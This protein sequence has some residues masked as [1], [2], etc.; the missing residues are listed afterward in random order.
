MTAKILMLPRYGG[1]GASSRVR[2]LQYVPFL[3]GAG[4][5]VDVAPLL[6]DEY[7]RRTYQGRR[8]FGVI[9]QSY[10]G[11][12]L[13]MGRMASYDLLWVE[14]E[15]WPWL[16]AFLERAGTRMAGRVVVD[17]DDA[18]FH[19]Y[20]HH[21]SAIVRRM[22]GSKI[23]E[24]MRYA[25]AVTV[26]NAYLG[27]RARCAGSEKQLWLPTVVDL[28]RY[29]TPPNAEK[30]DPLVIGWIGSPATAA[31]LQLVAPALE[32]LS[33]QYQ[34]RCLAIGARADQLQGT[35]FE[36][37]SW[38]EGDEVAQLQ[39]FDIGIMPLPDE[40]W[41]RGKCGYKLIQYM[42]C[43]LPVVA[44]PVGIN[45]EIVRHG[46]NG[47][48]A[49]KEPEWIEAL[50]TLVADA[51]LRASMGMM[52]R[53]LVEDVYSLQAQAPRLQTLFRELVESHV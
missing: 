50:Q 53:Q 35:P 39:R 38:S 36:S 27:D 15:L 1:L 12:M 37:V 14:K 10:F 43:G 31:Y 8:A 11:R 42:A 23:D 2:F 32:S 48:Q 30:D 51:A 33:R 25:D 21:A 9:M 49:T 17:Y 34:I 19:R 52:G 26:G 45:R 18:I 13:T 16:P 40:P 29:G 28:E 3:T 47:F 7:V 6:S 24:V 44:S 46:E 5:Q 22:L 41:E 20:D 4:Y